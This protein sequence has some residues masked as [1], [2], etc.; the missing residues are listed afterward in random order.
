M[1]KII[2]EPNVNPTITLSEKDYNR[3]VSLARAKAKQID[4][5]ALEYY[6]K[7]GACSIHIDAY[8]RRM[9]YASDEIVDTYKFDC[10]HGY[11]TSTGEFGET[12]F[13]IDKDT[14][15]RIFDF[16][17]D[18]VQGIFEKTFGRQLC[19]INEAIKLRRKAERDLKVFRILTITGWLVA[20]VLCIVAVLR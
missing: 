16:A 3:L 7:Y 1:E 6:K 2:K 8:M 18:Y 4:E 11:V 5:R 10:D 13:T 14:R 19:N 15:Q 9:N 17:R 12:R 20:I